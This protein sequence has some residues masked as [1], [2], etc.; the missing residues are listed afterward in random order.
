MM[1]RSE[2]QEVFLAAR[3]CRVFDGGARIGDPPT[4][5]GAGGVSETR[6]SRPACGPR[7]PHAAGG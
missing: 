6:E 4:I 2:G 7:T 5:P 3:A 1:R